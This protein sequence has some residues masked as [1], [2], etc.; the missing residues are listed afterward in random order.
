MIVVIRRQARACLFSFVSA[1]ALLPATAQAQETSLQNKGKQNI[2]N[3]EESNADTI[4]VT[5]HSLSSSGDAAVLP[6]AVLADEE[7]VHRRRGTLGETLEG[8]PGVHMDNFGA[9]AS[10]PVIRGQTLPRIEILTDGANLFDV[11]SVSPDH[12]I[13]TDPLLLDAIEIQRGPA[14]VRYGGSAVNGAIN[15]IDSKI[16]KTLPDKEAT[17][18]SELRFGSADKEKAAAGRLT[19]ALGPVAL[20]AEGS[21]SQRADYDVPD[22]YGADKLKDSFGKSSSYAFGA[23]WITDKGYIGASYARQDAEYGLPG[24]S[25]ANGVCHTHYYSDYLDLH[26]SAHAGFVDPVTS[27]DSHTAYIDLRSERV[28]L[29]ADYENLLPGFSH[30]RLRGSYTDYQHDEVDGR[31]LF[32]RYTNEVWDGRIELTHKPLFGFTGTFGGQYT[33]GTF[34]G[35][36]INDLAVP[37]PDDDYGLDGVPDYLTE[38]IGIF[39]SERRS[40]GPV[41]FEIA[42]RKDWRE[43]SASPPPFRTTLP[44]DN[45]YS[46]NY[47]P[48]WREILEERSLNSFYQQNPPTKHDPFSASLG[49]T[50]NIKG[51]YAAAL[52][53]AHTERAPSVRELYASGNNMATNSY[54]QGLVQSPGDWLWDSFPVSFAPSAPDLIEKTDSINL[55]F[56]KT[57]GPLEFEAGLFYQDIEDYVFAR[58]LD[59]DDETGVP[60][61]WLIYTAADASFTGIDGQ[62]SYGFT[63]KARVTV[64]GDYVDANLKSQDDN[65]PRIPPGRLGARLDWA[66]GPLSADVEYYRTF[67]QDEVAS[68]ETQTDGY[69]MVNATIAYRLEVEGGSELEIY[70]RGTNLTDELAFVHTSFVKDQSPLRGRNL[71]LGL[72]TKF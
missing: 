50:W 35:L 71:V 9:G 46:Q 57:G 15:L 49:A 54:E 13:V 41:D 63:P 24:H 62:I 25:H 23:S 19:T 38:N 14:A 4:I 64:F 17:G 1:L 60:H 47:G 16:P 36:N 22:E 45:W 65:L 43:I 27:P 12:A 55:T 7:L 3:T 31:T 21:Y 52:S 20:H 39:L 58:F 28:D 26:C 42:A 59:M 70:A 29:R 53:L 67:E 66:Q 11:A 37:F 8:L 5:G 40:F 72:R 51:G 44:E 69:N 32:T 6:V 48:D 30:V 2:E 34:T 33:D 68:Y 18:A 56:R 10:R 61:N